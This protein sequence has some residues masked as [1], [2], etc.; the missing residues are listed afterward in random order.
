MT[1]LSKAATQDNPL[2][3]V[4]IPAYNGSRY[5][6]Q[7]IDSVLMQTY[8]SYELIVIDD[9]STDNTELV[10]QPY[11][12]KGD[13]Q[14][15]AEIRYMYQT[16]QGVGAARNHGIRLAQAEWI[17]FLDQDDVWF[18]D[19]LA[20]QV[21]CLQS[22][23]QLG[24]VHS[25]WQI[26]DAAGRLRSTVQPWQGLPILDREA[27]LQ[28]KPVFLGAMLFRRDWLA[29]VGGFREQWQQTGDVDLVL[30]L[31]SLGCPAAWV[32]Q[33]TV[34]Y[35]QHST[36]TSHNVLEQSQELEAVLEQFWSQTDLPEAIRSLERASR[37]Q[38][39]VWSAWRFYQ[40]GD[41]KQMAACLEKALRF[42]NKPLTAKI[43]DWVEQFKLYSAEYGVELDLFT[44]SQSSAWRKV[45]QI[46]LLRKK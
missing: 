23:P 4:I 15:R 29:K 31:A 40:S 12:Q 26:I 35:R 19:K 44:L 3:S 13:Q 1:E 17:A 10:L 34:K 22:Q 45:T 24:I 27:W 21:A 8:R 46:S 32:K 14:E 7:A 42:T 18:P 30:R 2:I 28:W 33:A 37:Y 16:N 11:L 38:S 6:A 43:C 9:G 41:E 5:L 36:N 39:W 25:G 20:L